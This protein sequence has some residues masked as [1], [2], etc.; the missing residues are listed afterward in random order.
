MTTTENILNISYETTGGFTRNTKVYP[1]TVEM[2]GAGT[3]FFV[4]GPNRRSF[5]IR[6]VY[7]RHYEKW[8]IMS[9]RRGNWRLMGE[10]DGLPAFIKEAIAAAKNA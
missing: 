8:V 10:L 1:E 4:S 2:S 3:R 9:T 5:E 6:N 7:C